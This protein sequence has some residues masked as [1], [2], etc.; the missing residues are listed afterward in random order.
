[1]IGSDEDFMKKKKKREPSKNTKKPRPETAKTGRPAFMGSEFDQLGQDLMGGTESA[2]PAQPKAKRPQ[3]SKQP[4][5][6]VQAP[7]SKTIQSI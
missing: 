2:P 5:P 3:S 4:L 1:M 6:P 7:G